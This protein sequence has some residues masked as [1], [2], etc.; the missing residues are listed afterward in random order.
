MRLEP[1]DGEPDPFR[2]INTKT[3]KP[4]KLQQR[5]RLS[6]YAYLQIPPPDDLIRGI[7]TSRII[8][9]RETKPPPL[10]EQSLVETS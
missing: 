4:V 2:A 7:Q 8:R 9:N 3:N 6:A 5:E 1:A 10:Q